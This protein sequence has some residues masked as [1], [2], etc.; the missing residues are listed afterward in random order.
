MSRQKKKGIWY[1]QESTSLDSLSV[2]IARP[3]S[4]DNYRQHVNS[5]IYLKYNIMI[6]TQHADS[7]IIQQ[8]GGH[9]F[10]QP[11]FSSQELL[12]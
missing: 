10:T 11:A 9:A 4:Y 6:T 1:K 7:I 8:A 3:P 2:V 5:I 12:I